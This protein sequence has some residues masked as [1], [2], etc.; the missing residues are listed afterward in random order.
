M[1]LDADAAAEM[2]PAGQSV[3]GV[4]VLAVNWPL[5]QAVHDEAL[6]RL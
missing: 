1:Q 6:P 3:H 5:V 4:D 2:V